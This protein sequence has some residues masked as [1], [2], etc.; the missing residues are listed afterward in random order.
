MQQ[1][2]RLGAVSKP[3]SELVPPNIQIHSYDEAD[4]AARDFAGSIASAYRLSTRKTT[5]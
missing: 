4:K 3:A 1:K 2:N 5:M